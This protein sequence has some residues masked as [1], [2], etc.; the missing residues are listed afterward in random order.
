MTL[1]A[2]SARTLVLRL[3]TLGVQVPTSI[4]LARWLGVEGKGNYT[5]LTVVPWLVAFV[6]LGGLNTAQTYLV[7]ARKATL[8]AV[9]FQSA[10]CVLVL[11]IP[12][13]AV[14]LWLVAPQAMEMIPRKLLWLSAVLVPVVISRL[15]VLA[16]LLGLERIDNY[17]LIHLYTSL[18]VFVSLFIL[19]VV[20]GYGV[21][22]ALAGFVAAQAVVLPVAFFWIRQAG[23]SGTQG[24]SGGELA[25]WSLLKSSLAYGL[26]GHPAGVLALFNQRLDIFLLG[27]LASPAEVGLYAVA[28]AVAETIWHVPTSVNLNLFPRVAAI[29]ALEGA[30]RLPRACRMTLLL[31]A[32]LAF[33][34]ALFGKLLVG[35]LFGSSFLPSNG[36]LLALLPG[37]LALSVASVF[38]SYFAGV[39]RRH[40]QSISAGVSF[41]MGLGLCL[42]LIPAYGAIG[43]AV[44]SSASYSLQMAVSIALFRRLGKIS[45]K[46]FF[47]PHPGDLKYL[48]ETFR[49]LF[50]QTS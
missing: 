6:A 29:G 45:W 25:G 26:K 12:A 28:V 47:L 49:G 24:R 40:Y 19:V 2:G 35:I 8:R 27:A 37:V 50:K 46:E 32:G 17:N 1:A 7:S 41:V 48:L 21:G 30:R 42:W 9:T 13:V 3:V 34:L 44:A 33:P 22:G 39:N 20:L 31:S 18:L 10:L 36:P 43:A 5:L 16:V 11:S 4:L 14:Y 23:R 38:E 15:L